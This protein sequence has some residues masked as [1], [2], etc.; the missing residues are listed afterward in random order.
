MIGY[1]RRGY[2]YR[3][4]PQEY[5]TARDFYTDYKSEAEI[6]GLDGLLWRRD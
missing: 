2:E 4:L 5:L 6:V 1:D 3:A